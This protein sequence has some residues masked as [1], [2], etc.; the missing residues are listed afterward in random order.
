MR[1]CF[2]LFYSLFAARCLLLLDVRF[3]L[4]S[5]SRCWLL[6]VGLGRWSF[7]VFG[8]FG[9]G[10]GLLGC[11]LLVAGFMRLLVGLLFVARGARCYLLSL[12]S[13]CVC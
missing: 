6:L 9:F 11:W 4:L 7:V 8:Y 10:F 12:S 13:L 3:S 2:L 5:C 1:C